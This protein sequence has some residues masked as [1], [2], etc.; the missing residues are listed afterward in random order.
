VLGL[1]LLVGGLFYISSRSAVMGQAERSYRE[2]LYASKPMDEYFREESFASLT[3]KLV[4]RSSS[5]AS[6]MVV[7]IGF[8]KWGSDGRKKWEIFKACR[9]RLRNEGES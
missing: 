4:T 3:N 2:L 6:I 9:R 7:N 5:R 8:D 1:G